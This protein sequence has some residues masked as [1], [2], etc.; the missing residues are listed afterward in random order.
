MLQNLP[1]ILPTGKQLLPRH[2]IRLIFILD[3]AQKI[4]GKGKSPAA[5]VRQPMLL[6]F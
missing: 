1:R 2:P 5:T 3:F 6:A 4:G